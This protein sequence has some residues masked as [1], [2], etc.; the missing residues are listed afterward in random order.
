[1]FSLLISVTSKSSIH[2]LFYG[3]CIIIFSHGKQKQFKDDH[4]HVYKK[5]SYYQYTHKE[6]REMSKT[7]AHHYE[8]ICLKIQEILLTQIQEPRNSFV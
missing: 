2:T 5:T 1:M 3:Q 7:K 6:T 8:I 4:S